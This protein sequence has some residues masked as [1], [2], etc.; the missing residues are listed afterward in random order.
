LGRKLIHTSHLP[1]AS[2]AKMSATAEQSTL[3][4]TH[5]ALD[6]LTPTRAEMASE[7]PT[8]RVDASAPVSVKMLT[9]GLV[10]L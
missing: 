5:D 10:G 7:K 2:D 4:G 1:S 3:G 9:W 6:V 8:L